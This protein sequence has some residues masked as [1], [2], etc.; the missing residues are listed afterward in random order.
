MHEK[1]KTLLLSIIKKHLPEARVYLFGSR[2]Q[3]TNAPHADI[4][5]ALD[6]GKEI[7]IDIIGE[8]R[9]EFIEAV[10]PFF[11]DVVDLYS[12]SDVMKEQ[13]LK[14]RVVWKS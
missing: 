12:V 2:A 1:Y 4:D 6:I 5:L 11:I 7:E 8:I 3:G 13:I 14:H 9:D 10:I